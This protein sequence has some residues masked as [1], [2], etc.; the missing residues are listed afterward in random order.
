[1]MEMGWPAAFLLAVV[2]LI[3]AALINNQWARAHELGTNLSIRAYQLESIEAN[4]E[5]EVQRHKIGDLSTALEE[6]EVELNTWRRRYGQGL[7]D[8]EDE[9]S[10]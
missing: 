3:A 1:M 5:L 10:H 2:A 4:K 6:A 8:L 9:R 7:E